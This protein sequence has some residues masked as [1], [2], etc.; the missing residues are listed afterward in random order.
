MWLRRGALQNLCLVAAALQSMASFH[1]NMFVLRDLV[2]GEKP[3]LTCTLKVL[4]RWG[5]ETLSLCRFW[6]V[7][8]LS[9]GTY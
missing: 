1:Q 8:L 4:R 9:S 2:L 5:P 3:E 7:A 6:N